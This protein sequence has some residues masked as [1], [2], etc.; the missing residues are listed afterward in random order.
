LSELAWVAELN[1]GRELRFNSPLPAAELAN[2]GAVYLE[3][4]SDLKTW[5]VI[6]EITADEQLRDP[7]PT[8]STAR[9]YRVRTDSGAV[10]PSASTEVIAPK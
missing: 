5:E 9:F 3:A 2:L 1:E 7:A 10:V 6:G 4:S 8:N